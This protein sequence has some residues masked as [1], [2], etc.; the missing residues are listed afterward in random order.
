MCLSSNVES[1]SYVESKSYVESESDVDSESDIE[2]ESDVESKSDIVK[3]IFYF[4][5]VDFLF[6]FIPPCCQSF[7]EHG[8][9]FITWDLLA[10][11]ALQQ[12]FPLTTGTRG[13]FCIN[14]RGVHISIKVVFSCE[15]SSIPTTQGC[16]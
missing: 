12:S 7:L 11:L 1:E 4:K 9:H 6:Y 2:S 8:E 16:N 13:Y 3:Y 10:L 14:N 15:S 5:N